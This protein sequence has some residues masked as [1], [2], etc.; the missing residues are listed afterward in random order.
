MLAVSSKQYALT[1]FTGT[2]ISITVPSQHVTSQVQTPV[3][4]PI[5]SIGQEKLIDL[6][7]IKDLFDYKFTNYLVDF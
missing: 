7:A 1:E 6:H 2:D 4:L 5:A 3:E